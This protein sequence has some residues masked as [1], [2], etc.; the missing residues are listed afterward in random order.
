MFGKLSWGLFHEP[1]KLLEQ[2]ISAKC[3]SDGDIFN[4]VF[5]RD[6]S[7]AWRAMLGKLS[8]GRFASRARFMILEDRVLSSVKAHL[9]SYRTSF[10]IV[11]DYIF[12]DFLANLQMVPLLLFALP[13]Y[14]VIL[15][16]GSDIVLMDQR[17]RQ[18]LHKPDMFGG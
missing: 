8:R 13:L 17:L 16:N 18:I 7:H 14:A 2:I 9:S 15:C 3:L 10:M 5:R 1:R 6:A 11:E 12:I 4:H